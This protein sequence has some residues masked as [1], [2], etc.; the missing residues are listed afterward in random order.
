MYLSLYLSFVGQVVSPRQCDQSS[1]RPQVSLKVFSKC[2]CLHRCLFLVNWVQA[3]H[4]SNWT[5]RAASSQQPEQWPPCRPPG[6]RCS[7]YQM[8]CHTLPWSASSGN[9][10]VMASV[11][12]QY[13]QGQLSWYDHEFMIRSIL[14]IGVVVVLKS[15]SPVSE[16][17]KEASIVGSHD[18]QPCFVHPGQVF[19]H[20]PVTKVGRKLKERN[21]AEHY[22]WLRK[23]IDWI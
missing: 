21:Q 1:Q 22:L 14:T 13:F 9:Y 5:H 19:S 15:A 12:D 8:H 16:K 2:I 20:P 17:S 6:C 23:L 3:Y 11:Q 4:C 7:S 18:S 10:F